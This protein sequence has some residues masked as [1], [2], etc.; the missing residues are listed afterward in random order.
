MSLAA[1]AVPENTLASSSEPRNGTLTVTRL[2][3]PGLLAPVHCAPQPDRLPQPTRHQPVLVPAVVLALLARR[4]P[5][6]YS[7]IP[8]ELIA[9]AAMC[10]L[11]SLYDAGLETAW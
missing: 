10:Q 1:S 3:V 11:P 5:S 4:T 9:A 7:F 8:A 2:L 6:T